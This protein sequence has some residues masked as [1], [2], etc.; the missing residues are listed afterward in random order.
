[1]KNICPDYHPMTNSIW[2]Q[3]EAGLSEVL[4]KLYNI[5]GSS[6]SG[7]NKFS[8]YFSLHHLSC[9]VQSL[10]SRICPP[11]SSPPLLLVSCV[12]NPSPPRAA[13]PPVLTV[14][15]PVPPSPHQTGPWD[16][17]QV[18][19]RRDSGSLIPS[20]SGWCWEPLLAEVFHLPVLRRNRVLNPDLGRQVLSLVVIVVVVQCSW[21]ASLQKELQLRSLCACCVHTL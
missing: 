4:R 1:M 11:A 10:G 8:T 7:K 18:V 14:P 12:T 2:F 9:T 17:A 3:E 16:P 19:A 20:F 5:C 15:R 6:H 21:R 13:P